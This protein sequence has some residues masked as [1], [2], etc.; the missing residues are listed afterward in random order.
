DQLTGE[1]RTEQRLRRLP[2]LV[3]SSDPE[4]AQPLAIGRPHLPQVDH[5]VQEE[6]EALE[7]RRRD[8]EGPLATARPQEEGPGKVDEALVHEVGPEI[9]E[10]AALASVHLRGWQ[11]VGDVRAA[12]VPHAPV[13]AEGGGESTDDRVAQVQVVRMNDQVDIVAEVRRP[14]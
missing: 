10:E 3:A 8:V 2:E 11:V 5:V 4:L 14:A 7:C 1:R 9:E 12:L 13:E 6:G